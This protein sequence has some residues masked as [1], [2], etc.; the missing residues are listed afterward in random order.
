MSD[1]QAPHS[2]GDPNDPIIQNS[3]TSEY[4][5]EVETDQKEAKAQSK[6][7]YNNNQPPVDV[8]VDVH[9][10]KDKSSFWSNAIQIVSVS[11]NVAMVLFTYWL[12]TQ[13][14]ESVDIA[15][16][17]LADS[18]KNDSLN[19]IDDRVR[20]SF[21]SVQ[22]ITN[23]NRDTTNIALTKKSLT[24]QIISIKEPPRQFEVFNMPSLE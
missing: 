11:V 7:P 10:P 24:A 14:K 17:A 9:I 19:R 5:S 23:Y 13:T 6:P 1:E 4:V 20:N 18:R 3:S 21:D 22:R 2:N 15:S 12:F 16:K 8:N